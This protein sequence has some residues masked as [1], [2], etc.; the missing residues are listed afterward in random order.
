MVTVH[1]HGSQG[2][3][4]LTDRPEFQ[5][6]QAQL[7][8]LEKFKDGYAFFHESVKKYGMEMQGH[9]GWIFSS[10]E[11][12]EIKITDVAELPEEAA[13]PDPVYDKELEAK[14]PCPAE[15]EFAKKYLY[16][17]VV[18]CN[19][20][21][22][23]LM[24]EKD[25]SG[26]MSTKTEEKAQFVIHPTADGDNAVFIENVAEKERLSLKADDKGFCWS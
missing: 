8:K 3:A 22:R 20:Y 19:F 4:N 13:I 7:I 25:R 5:G 24:A 14:F 11:P 9:G 16:T 18:I 1:A 17:P 10:E 6:T 2:F 15:L 23:L 12:V 21:Q 26:F